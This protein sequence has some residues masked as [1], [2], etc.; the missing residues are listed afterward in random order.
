M[1]Y[2]ILKVVAGLDVVVGGEK[3][4]QGSI[5]QLEGQRNATT[6]EREDPSPRL[7]LP[8]SLA[9]VALSLTADATP[10]AL[11]P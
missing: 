6:N 8:L 4:L 7:P 11:R 5:V 1:A 2:G 10:P 3:W 9:Q